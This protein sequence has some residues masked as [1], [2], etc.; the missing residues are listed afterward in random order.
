M[1]VN[2]H[3]LS[4]GIIAA[5]AGGIEENHKIPSKDNRSWPKTCNRT[6]TIMLG[7]SLVQQYYSLLH[8]KEIQCLSDRLISR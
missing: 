3:A 2:G 5:L 8:W 7:E 1:E 4:W 6:A